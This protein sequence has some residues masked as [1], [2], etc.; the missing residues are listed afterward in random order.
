MFTSSS[1][2]LILMLYP[3]RDL[4][5]SLLLA[6]T[7]APSDS[8]PAPSTRGCSRPCPSLRTFFLLLSS[9][10]SRL[11]SREPIKQPPEFH[12]SPST[13]L[14]ERQRREASSFESDL[15]NSSFPSSSSLPVSDF[16]AP[17]PS[18]NLKV[19]MRMGRKLCPSRISTIGLLL[20]A[21]SC[22]PA[23]L[24]PVK[25]ENLE[26]LGKTPSASRPP[27]CNPLSLSRIP[28]ALF[29]ADS[30]ARSMA[31]A[32]RGEA[33]PL[34]S[35]GEEKKEGGPST[36]LGESLCTSWLGRGNTGGRERQDSTSDLAISSI[37]PMLPRQTS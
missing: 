19:E 33:P 29:L 6:P 27:P 17:R 7:S 36:T 14:E 11:G 25:E 1:G 23:A 12:R 3:Y 35:S 21:T 28:C 34:P 16:L 9:S 26:L 15:A 24:V 5:F 37:T 32:I 31:A 18:E 13:R 30:L 22:F 20:P 4:R 2:S 10:L 8:A